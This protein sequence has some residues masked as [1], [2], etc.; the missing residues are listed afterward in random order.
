MAFNKEYLTGLGISEEM[1]ERIVVEHAKG[2]QAEQQRTSA[3]A[4]RANGL[5]TQLTEANKK[6]EGYDP[7]WKTKAQQAETLRNQEIE[8]IKFGYALSSAIGKSG[9]RNAKTVEA[10]LNRDALK[11]NGDEIIGL[12]EQID[13]IKKDNAF[14]FEEERKPPIFMT[15]GGGQPDH[16]TDRKDAANAAFRAAFGKGE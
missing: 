7:E 12:K 4:A 5:D 9:A 11:L 15:G 1:A 6:L 2:V 14:L 8:K 16:E 10:L 13:S 3:E